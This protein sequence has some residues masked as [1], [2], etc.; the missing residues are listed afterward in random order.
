MTSL[1]STIRRFVWGVAASA[2]LLSAQ[3][4]TILHKYTLPDTP[5]GAFQN[6]VLPG[7]VPD[8]KGF[9]MGSVGSGLFRSFLEGPDVYWMV[10]DR[11]PNPFNSAGQRLFP[12]P[13]WT[14][15]LLKVKTTGSSIQ[16]LDRI[17][18]RM[19]DGTAT[20]GLPNNSRDELVRLCGPG[21]EAP[22]GGPVAPYNPNGLDTED[23][24]RTLD[25]NFWLVDE[26]SPSIIKVHPNGK[27][28]KR[29]LP[30]GLTLDGIGYPVSN[31]LPGIYGT[32]RKANRGFEG[33]TLG[34]DLRTLYAALQS[35]LVNPTNTVGNASRNTR[36]LSMDA[37]TE[38]VKAEYVYRF[39][40][41]T[42]FGLTNPSEMKISAVAALDPWR[43][44]VLERTDGVAKVYRVDL[45]KATNIL[46]TQWDDLATSPSLEALNA[47]GDLLAA[48]VK[49]LPKELMI[50]LSTIPGIPEKIEGMAILDWNTIA[51]SNDNDFN[52]APNGTCGPN[53]TSSTQN[54][55]LVIRLDRNLYF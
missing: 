8:D 9:L 40:P 16:I 45:T 43:L 13:G 20:T 49:E 46:G 50:D 32:K 17:P 23:V 39:Q 15:W 28:A 1:A 31:N 29:F 33:I 37:Y 3:S 24:V 7:T 35:P 18:L 53:L 19:P 26:H 34:W 41:V 14:P 42:E 47:D 11:G 36:I 25:G 30:A 21:T 44:L 54:H 27:V 52:V 22:V 10:T 48:G 12:I 4:G 6:A 2:G 51:F 55:I 5:I 38:Q